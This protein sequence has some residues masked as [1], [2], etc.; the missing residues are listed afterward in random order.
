MSW[1]AGGGRWRRGPDR[2][3]DLPPRRGRPRHCGRQ[4]LPTAGASSHWLRLG[5]QARRASCYHGLGPLVC[6]GWLQSR[7]PPDGSKGRPAMQAGGF[8]GRGLARAPDCRCGRE[9]GGSIGASERRPSVGRG[10]PREKVALRSRSREKSGMRGAVATKAGERKQPSPAYIAP[11]SRIQWGGTRIGP[12]QH[13]REEGGGGGSGPRVRARGS[14]GSSRRSDQASGAQEEEAQEVLATGSATNTRRRRSGR[15]AGAKGEDDD[16]QGAREVCVLA[17]RKTG[18]PVRRANRE[19]RVL[20]K[21]TER[22]DVLLKPGRRRC[23][24]SLKLGQKKNSSLWA[25][26]ICMHFAPRYFTIVFDN[27]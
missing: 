14:A 20:E 10:G 22:E 15:A 9:R 1:R 21:G 8:R 24:A 23:G 27:L 7:R 12:R 13:P 26:G 4:S 6:D 19:R 25:P 16:G 11:R 18:L 2:R 5:G 17:T 3:L